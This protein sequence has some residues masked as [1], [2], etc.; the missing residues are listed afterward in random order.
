M[1]S[2]NNWIQTTFN[3]TNLI[4]GV[5]LLSLPLAFKYTALPLAFIM[6]LCFAL[7]TSSTAKILAACQDL[8]MRRTGEPLLS[9]GDIGHAVFGMKGR[10]FIQVLFCCELFAASVALLILSADTLHHFVKFFGYE[11]LS[12]VD[13]KLIVWAIVT[14]A[15]WPRSLR[16][17][18]YTSLLGI[19][20]IVNLIFVI[21]FDGF[22]KQ[23]EP[24]SLLVPVAPSVLPKELMKVPL[25]IGLIMSGYSGHA[26]F[27]SFYASMREPHLFGRAINVSYTVATVMYLLVGTCGYLMFGDHVNGLIVFNLDSEVYPRV[28]FLVT[29]VLIIINPATKYPL[30]MFPLLQDLE[31]F[32]FR[33]DLVFGVPVSDSVEAHIKEEEEERLIDENGLEYEETRAILLRV[34]SCGWLKRICFRTF[35][36]GLGLLTA[37]FFPEFEKVLGLLG[38]L[39]C[40]INSALFPFA[41]YLSFF[42]VLSSSGHL[43]LTKYST[44]DRIQDGVPQWKRRC[45]QLIMCIVSVLAVIG[46]VWAF[47]PSEVLTSDT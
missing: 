4:M 35:I 17:L 41:C 10:L 37:I 21:L 1:V 22:W 11:G 27:P 45:V 39:F 43:A 18:S 3:I 15:I 16:V 44:S 38:S 7:L 47:I 36:S 20:C 6:T 46:T 14:V 29:L 40:M 24:G 19:A 9:Y 30:T 32:V 34:N 25:S 26:C 5:S 13:V 23:D 42:P 8:H 2:G 28:L 12:L 33:N 31:A